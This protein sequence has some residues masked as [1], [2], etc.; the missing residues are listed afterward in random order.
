[1]D[2]SKLYN[3]FTES[4]ARI[5]KMLSDG[6]A[7]RPISLFIEPTYRCNFRCRMCQFLDLLDDPRLNEKRDE[8]LTIEEMCRAVD[9]VMPRGLIAISG[10]EPLLRG[11][12]MELVRYSCK[13]HKAYLV[14]NGI[15]LKE[16]IAREMVEL[17][18]K[19]FL[20]SGVVSVGISLE[21]LGETHDE[22]VQ[23]P[24]SFDKIVQ[25]VRYIVGQKK[26]S[27][28]RYPLIALKCVITSHNVGQLDALYQL[29]ER[30]GVDIFNPIT[31][32][33]MPAADRLEMDENVNADMHVEPFA[34]F[35]TTLLEN[36]LSTV[37]DRAA[38]STV[39]L[40]LTPPGIGKDDIIAVYE[41]RL[42]HSNKT[43]YSP[44][45]TAILSAYGELSPC[46]NYTVGN[47]RNEP[48]R[49][50]WNNE[51]MRAFRREL[52]KRRI[53]SACGACCMITS[54]GSPSQYPTLKRQAASGIKA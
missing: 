44:W 51:K 1:M 38:R 10:G 24:G 2:Y 41:N 31:H 23:A 25:N 21:A 36:Q 7:F 52:K 48:L 45:S 47:I 11:D 15:L 33:H 46:S 35:D 27:G 14:T 4:Y 34:D 18:C 50:L 42:D 13:R 22:I 39:R 9:F 19:D 5:P 54:Q 26:K 28:K 29:A 32:Y 37:I 12:I 8:E 17:G 3:F 16:E 53:F 43:C 20:G 49:E 6:R 40:R 30:T